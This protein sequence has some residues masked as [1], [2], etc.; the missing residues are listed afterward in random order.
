MG[1][2]LYDYQAEVLDRLRAGFRAGHR[3]QMLAAPTGAGKCLA[4]GTLVMLAS[5]EIVPAQ[6]VRRGDRLMG[7][8]G[9]PRN[10]LSV[11]SG[12]EM[13]YRVT[14]TKGDPYVVNAS[15]ILSLR[16]TPSSCA[17]YLADG[18]R[19]GINDDLVNVGVETFWR[20]SKSA[21]HSLKGWR[22]GAIQQF[23]R[24]E[25]DVGLLIPPYILGAWLGDGKLGS[26]CLSKPGCKLVDEWVEYG[27][28]LGYGARNE[29]GENRCP[30]WRLTRGRDGTSYNTIQSGLNLLGVLESRHIPDAYKY[31]SADV[32]REL[33]AGLIDSDGHIDKSG[34]DWL[35]K[36]ERLAKD[37]AFVCRSLGLAC[38]LSRQQKGIKSS[39][40][41]GWYWRATVSGD[42][43]Q[44]PMRDKKA[45]ARRQK[46]R[47][48]VHGIKVEPIGEGS[49]YGFELDGDRLFLLGDFTVTHN[50]ELA[51]A[52]LE[53]TAKAG[54]RAAMILDRIVLCD[55][56]SQR[57]QKYG[58]DHGVMQAGHWRRRPYEPI[59]ICSAQTLEKSGSF[60]DLKLLVVDEAHQTRAQTAEFIRNNTHIKVV[61]LSATPFTKGLGQIYSHVVSAVTTSELV[62]SK[63]LAPLKVFIAKEIDMTGAKKVA[64]EWAQDEVTERGMK[65]TGDIVAA[66]VQ[67]THEIFGGPR[68]TIVFCAG[69]TH[70]A[71]L[72]KKFAEAGYNFISLSYK[73]DDQYKQDVIADFAK[74]DTEIHGLIATDILTKGFDVPDTMIGVSAR[75]FT[76]SLSSHIQQ[77]GRVMRSH[78][79]KSFAAWIC[80]S[81]NY[82]R[83]AEDWDEVYAN[84]VTTLDDGREK[85]KKEPTEKEKEAAKCPKCSAFWPAHADICSCC[86]HVRVRRSLIEAV[87]GELVELFAS[88]QKAKRE[89]KQK[90]YAEL[91]WIGQVHGY[92]PGWAAHKMKEKFDVWPRGLDPEPVPASKEVMRWAQSRQIAWAK[93]RQREGA[94]A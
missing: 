78:P 49:Y 41:N 18:R 15:H 14:P 57:L 89:D 26:A 27:R 72:A 24:P 37:F 28:S 31:G 4:Y 58:I 25:D 3:T 93:S 73:D 48:L 61:G 23:E 8:D 40:F 81:G 85:P 79:S 63:R 21:R 64:G 75:P 69:V 80:H 2:Q 12:R 11:A 34:C 45:P 44:I 46:K 54:N 86:G 19:I 67:K 7:P 84:G 60:P 83:F 51:I 91:L 88:G 13:M 76:K 39:G 50:T 70:G 74:P 94:T 1:L 10:V 53:A 33:L 68:K 92:K 35:S 22:S 65:I 5:G 32:R 36:S 59:Q 90:W 82:V 71:D 62:A 87:P 20:S 56:T 6:N 52:L 66:W 30:T 77:M 16:R 47:H 29:A 42:L 38:Y 9:Q 17:F 55:Q 43:S